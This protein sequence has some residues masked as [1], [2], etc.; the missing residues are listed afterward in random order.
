MWSHPWNATA[1]GR[2]V[3]MELPSGPLRVW[4]EEAVEDGGEERDNPS[5]VV[6]SPLGQRRR[7][8]MNR[9][10]KPLT[11]EDSPRSDGERHG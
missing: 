11:V 3:G 9:P 6:E 10:G 8:E 7:I 4:C 1:P 2:R 5:F